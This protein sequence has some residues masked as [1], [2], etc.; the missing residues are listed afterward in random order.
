MLS[1]TLVAT[2]MVIGHPGFGGMPDDRELGTANPA[3]AA[4]EGAPVVAG[5]SVPEILA[6]PFPENLSGLTRR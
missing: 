2:P 6:A 1:V 5:L 4:L 3:F